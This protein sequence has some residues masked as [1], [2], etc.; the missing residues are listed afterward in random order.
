M[1]PSKMIV[2]LYLAGQINDKEL[3]ELIVTA[4]PLFKSNTHI[5]RVEKVIKELCEY[6]RAKP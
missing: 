5:F 3:A 1:N 2:A 6:E 4:L